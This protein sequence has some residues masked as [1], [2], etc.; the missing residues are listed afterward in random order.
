MEIDWKAIFAHPLMNMLFGALI[1]YIPMHIKDKRELAAKERL[2][3]EERKHSQEVEKKKI[4]YDERKNSYID[5]IRT[6][7][8]IYVDKGT[9]NSLPQIQISLGII[10]LFGSSAVANIANDA[11]DALIDYVISSGEK[12]AHCSDTG[13]VYAEVY[14]KMATAM[15][16]DLSIHETELC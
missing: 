7:N 9:A 5:Y 15:R 1:G 8:K 4:A 12:G 14:H 6:L 10:V 13:K 2:A 11:R 3:A 16:F